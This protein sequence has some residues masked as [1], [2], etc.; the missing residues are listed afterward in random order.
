MPEFRIYRLKPTQ[1]Q[2]FRWAPHT[3]GASTVKPK[4]YQQEGCVEASSPY[5]AWAALRQTGQ[6][7]EVGDMLE[8]ADG[9]LL[10]CKYVGFEPAKWFVA[11][12]QPAQGSTESPA[13]TATLP[14]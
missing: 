1:R 6:P 8:A 9:T 13:P 4:D 3:S 14:S 7:L 10:I 12:P 2:Q 5:A 11:E